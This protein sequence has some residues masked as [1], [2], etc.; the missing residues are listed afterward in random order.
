MLLTFKRK[1]SL[2]LSLPLWFFRSCQVFELFQS[3]KWRQMRLTKAKLVRFELEVGGSPKAKQRVLPYH[4][5]EA[6]K[7][8]AE[9]FLPSFVAEVY[10]NRKILKKVK[11]SLRSL[12]ALICCHVCLICRVW[13]CQVAAA[14]A[15]P[16]GLASEADK[17]KHEPC[18]LRAEWA[19]CARRKLCDKELPDVNISASSNEQVGLQL[20]NS[21]HETSVH[22]SAFRCTGCTSY[23]FAIV[24]TASCVMAQRKTALMQLYSWHQ[25]PHKLLRMKAWFIQQRVG[26]SFA[27]HVLNCFK[28]LEFEVFV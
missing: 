5:D 28:C 15:S 14:L 3:V 6:R 17:I 18:K 4:S 27:L 9:F 16:Q 7:H 19:E 8:F 12:R 10:E 24:I 2:W 25:G 22:S 26:R 11:T 13:P 21:K 1:S 20:T 23:Q